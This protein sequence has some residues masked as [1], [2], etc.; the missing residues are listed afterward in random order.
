M[1]TIIHHAIVATTWV[2]HSDFCELVELVGDRGKCWVSDTGMNGYLTFVL[3]PDGS[4][5]GWEESN[6]GDDL[7]D[8][9]VE[10]LSQDGFYCSWCEVAMGELPEGNGVKLTRH[11]SY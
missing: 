8:E 10:W 11:D 1:G 4:K 6:I 7:R 2:E 3:A 5:E 9:V